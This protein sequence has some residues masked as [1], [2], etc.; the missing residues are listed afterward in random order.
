M[1]VQVEDRRTEGSTILRQCQLVELYLLDV[2]VAICEKYKLQYFLDGGT[3]LGAMRH[4]GF[5]PWDDDVDVCMP[6]VDYQKFMQIAADEFPEGVLLQHPGE[7]PSDYIQHA[8]LRDRK[9]VFLEWYSQVQNPSGIFIDIFPFSKFPLVPR[10]FAK[11]MMRAKHVAYFCKQAHRIRAN[12]NVGQMFFH[13]MMCCLWSWADLMLWLGYVLLRM[14]CK[15][16]WNKAFGVV[17]FSTNG[18]EEKDLFPLE[19]HSFEGRDLLVPSNAD[20]YLQLLYGD[21]RKLPPESDRHGTHKVALILPTQAPKVW[22][23][24]PYEGGTT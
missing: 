4:D 13:F 10:S 23:A 15:K 11:R 7:F 19:R 9:S 3:L 17:D 20:K 18:I 1:R 5:I 14:V 8:R 24:M 12:R 6:E 21:W 2:F 16:G 22:W